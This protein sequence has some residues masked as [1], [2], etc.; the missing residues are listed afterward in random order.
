MLWK[1]FHDGKYKANE[2][3]CYK[4]TIVNVLIML[5]REISNE[6]RFMGINAFCT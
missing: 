6:N 3:Q 2:Q 1:T 4:Q 5:M